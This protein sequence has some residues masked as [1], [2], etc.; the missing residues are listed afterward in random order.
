MQLKRVIKGT[1]WYS[2]V[3]V[4]TSGVSLILLPLLTR[5]LS[6]TEF[7]VLSTAT[8]VSLLLTP[9]VTLGLGASVARYF[10]EYKDDESKFISLFS[11]SFWV[12]L[13]AGF[14]VVL[15]ICGLFWFEVIDSIAGVNFWHLAPV[16]ILLISNPPRDIGGQLLTAQEKHRNSCM[17]QIS[18]FSVATLATFILLLVFNQQSMGRLTAKCLGGLVS[19]FVVFKLLDF[20]M[21]L[22]PRVDPI[23]LRVSL[24]YGLPLIPYGFAMGAMMYSDRLILEHYMK[25]EDVGLFSAAKTVAMGANF[26]YSSTT[27]S[28]MPRYLDLKSA[29]KEG[30]ASD[31]QWTKM[32]FFVI[33]ALVFVQLAP[34]V[35]PVIVD[36]EYVGSGD[37]LPI[38]ALAIYFNGVF[39]SQA[40]Y[41]NYLKKNAWLPVFATIGLAINIAS[42]VFLIPQY[43]LSGAAWS[44]VVG[45]F[46]MNM[47]LLIFCVV[48]KSDLIERVYIPFA[49]ML[50]CGVSMY[51]VCEFAV[52]GSLVQQSLLFCAVLICVAGLWL[53]GRKLISNK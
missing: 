51:V 12:Q 9:F 26:I 31:V 11:A 25:M 30:E 52:V 48:Y 16:M 40:T 18:A 34:Y 43:G 33:V 28:W 7:G 49:A 38:F 42:C 24:R 37:L 29:S 14:V 15:F 6:P 2:I 27:R 45:F 20:S 35:Y 39:V 13:C 1:F 23:E 8:A 47:I 44:N 46:A 22:K 53:L 10:Y 21:Y 32:I 4:L 19:V 50:V 36:K 5:V 17:I 41:I 3:G